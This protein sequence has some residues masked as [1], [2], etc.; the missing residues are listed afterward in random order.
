MILPSYLD[1]LAARAR[2]GAQSIR[3][4]IPGR[5]EPPGLGN[6]RLLEM[7]EESIP[8]PLPPVHEQASDRDA[9]PP[10]HAV[11]Q[12]HRADGPGAD[13]TGAPL[14]TSNLAANETTREVIAESARPVTPVWTAEPTHRSE[15]VTAPPDLWLP[16]PEAALR[17]DPDQSNPEPPVPRE[18]GVQAEQES[19]ARTP[20]IAHSSQMEDGPVGVHQAHDIDA[21]L[22]D[23]TTRRSVTPSEPAG[24]S[25]TPTTNPATAAVKPSDDR[26]RTDIQ[27][28]MESPAEPMVTPRALA[29]APASVSGL[30]VPEISAQPEAFRPARAAPPAAEAEGPVIEVTIG[31]VEVRATPPREEP[32]RQRAR[33]RGRPPMPLDEY[34][35]QRSG[36]S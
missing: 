26:P 7:V 9:A 25:A 13:Q 19:Q 1:R 17:N 24:P 29:A 33:A 27:P 18:A 21:G 14:G 3:P 16:R 28:S 30:A 15:D 11:A 20:L 31:R 35:R 22:V 2:G 8:G 12:Q 10:Q 6:L 34:L 32:R 4:R 5:F 23:R 36:K